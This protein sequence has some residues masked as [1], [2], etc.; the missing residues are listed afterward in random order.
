[1]NNYVTHS[2]FNKFIHTSLLLIKIWN[3]KDKLFMQ[4]N[5]NYRL[6][7]I[8]KPLHILNFFLHFKWKIGLCIKLK[9]NFC[10]QSLVTTDRNWNLMGFTF[11]SSDQQ[12]SDL[13]VENNLMQR[14]P[15]ACYCTCLFSRN[16]KFNSYCL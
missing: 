10:T 3:Y 15:F 12:L 13:N 16:L 4:R 14:H 11:C 5:N 7:I 6:Q 2:D 9:L 8:K 1:M